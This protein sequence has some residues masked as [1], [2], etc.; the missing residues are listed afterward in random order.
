MKQGIIFHIQKYSIHDGPGIRTTVF[1]K[2][3]PLRCQWCH[4]P[5]GISN[6]PELVTIGS[7]C[8]GC[9][10]C[11]L[12]CPNGAVAL[13]APAVDSENQEVT[14]T[15]AL[16]VSLGA[17]R[18][19]P[20]AVTDR[21][22]CTVCGKCADLCPTQAR[23]IVG[24]C[25]TSDWVMEQ[26]LKD[27]VFYEQSGGGVTF[28]GGE[29]LMQPEFLLDLLKRCKAE[30]ISTAVDTSGC[31]P[32]DSLEKIM[33]FT[34]LFLYD[35]KLTDPSRHSEYTGASNQ[36][37]LENL[38]RLAKRR[39]SIIARIPMIPGINDHE[40]NIIA[41]GRFL[42]GLGIMQ[43]SILPYHDIGS[44]KYAR[45]G[46]TYALG[47]TAQPSDEAVSKVKGILEGFGL[48]VNIGG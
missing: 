14:R 30:G 8:I 27:R 2:G 26:V 25:V 43:A 32:W 38:S 41:T 23:K 48:A 39:P 20:V 6:E 9:G 21:G 22:K 44:D 31:V 40:D 12:V 3:C 46:K 11:I 7:R 10:M 35:V 15:P 29:P 28:S 47:D 4:N 36:L 17:T 42:A 13:S 16:E 1:L 19:R 5:E 34:D 45:L 33:P 37:I 24:M 18:S